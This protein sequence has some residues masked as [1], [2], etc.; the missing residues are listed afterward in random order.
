MTT[1]PNDSEPTASKGA[2][3]RFVLLHEEARLRGFKNALAFR[4]W[5]A[6]RDVVLRRD[7]K[8]IWVAPSDV[9][10]AV[11]RIPPRGTESSVASAVAAIQS[12]KR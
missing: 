11:E 4:R 3:P 10:R 7:G 12:R 6:K 5:C 9:D 1:A 8:K 2:A